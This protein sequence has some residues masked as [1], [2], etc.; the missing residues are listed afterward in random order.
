MTIDLRLG[1]WQT[2]MADID[3]VDAII[4]DPPYSERTHAAYRTGGVVDDAGRELIAYS[5]MDPVEVHLF[6][7]HWAPRCIGWFVIMS[8]HQLSR[9]W[10][11]ELED[12]GLYVFAPLPFIQKRIRLAGDGPSSWTTWINVARPRNQEFQRWGTLPGAYFGNVEKNGGVVVGAKPLSL[13]RSIV[14]DYS[15]PGDLI[16]DPFAGSGSTL[17]AAASEGRRAVGAEMDP[18]TYAYAMKRIK[19]GYTEQMFPV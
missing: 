13:M 16:C 6:C 10:Q 3:Q 17:I 2:A 14:R 4:A 11:Q 15:R 7:R 19:G 5:H 9:V 1:S 18:N 8:D 12:V